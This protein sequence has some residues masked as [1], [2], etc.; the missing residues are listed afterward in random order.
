M[1]E[2]AGIAVEGISIGGLET[3]IQLPGMKLAFDMGCCP[4]SAVSRPTVLFTHAHVDHMS[5]VIS[6][7]ATRSLM[8]MAPP[9]YVVPPAIFEDFNAL[10]DV[11]RRLDGSDLPC[12]VVPVGPGDQF[13]PNKRHVVRP[14]RS[15]HRVESQGYTI[16]E[17]RS[18]LRQDLTGQPPQVIREAR[19]RGEDVSELSEIPLVSFTG[20]TR[21][22][23]I[24][25]QTDF[26]R[27]RLLIMEVTFFDDRVTVSQARNKGH[28]HFDEV[29]ARHALFQNDAI[30][31]THTSQRYKREEVLRILD[32][33][34]PPPFRAKVSL[35]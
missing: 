27:S 22:E 20:D 35:L 21:I 26:Q 10:F 9:T 34:L 23:M 7:C 5:A 17:K 33:K 19:E 13:A 11:W 28:I 1:L 31:M 16:Y 2:L 15:I 3:C 14:A 32:D 4:R 24:E 25:Q 12:K 29:V 18:R 6:H 8:G 30:L